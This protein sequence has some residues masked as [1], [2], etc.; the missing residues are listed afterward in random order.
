MQLMLIR[1]S[2]KPANAEKALK[3]ET[4]WTKYYDIVDAKAD[5]IFLKRT[6]KLTTTPRMI[7]VQRFLRFVERSLTLKYG[8][9]DLVTLPKSKLGW[10]KLIAS[11]DDTP[12]MVARKTDGGV[13]LIL[14]DEIG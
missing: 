7:I 6:G 11:Y 3:F 14:M 13:V 2:G 4:E 1:Q 8:S 10:Q 9:E 12:I 5:K